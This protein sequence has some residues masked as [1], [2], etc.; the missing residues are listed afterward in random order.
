M[1]INQKYGIMNGRNLLTKKYRNTKEALSLE[2]RSQWQNEPLS[3]PLAL[4]VLLYFGDR[5]RRDI[6]AYLKILLDSMEG[7]VY[8]DD[9]QVT[10]LHVYKEIDVDDPRVVVQ[11]V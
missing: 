10:E 7:I 3:E 8:E 11:V 5:R 1:P 6:D 9:V 2:T 4:N